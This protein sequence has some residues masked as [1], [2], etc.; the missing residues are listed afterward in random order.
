MCCRE[1]TKVTTYQYKPLLAQSLPN[2]ALGAAPL[3]TC[4]VQEIPAK[5]VVGMA[6]RALLFSKN[7]DTAESLTAVLKQAG[8]TGELCTD[9]FAAM[10]KGTKQPFSCVI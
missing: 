10:E 9:I 4:P 5:L 8:I 6:P 2:P 7:P 1:V 3:V